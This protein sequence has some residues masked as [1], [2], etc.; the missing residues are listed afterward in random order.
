MYDFAV[1]QVAWYEK[2]NEYVEKFL[3]FCNREIIRSR[4][5][6]R[7]IAAYA[8]ETDGDDP[9]TRKIFGG[10]Y[11]SGDTRKLLRERAKY[12]RE[13]KH[14]NARIEHYRAEAAEYER[15]IG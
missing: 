5:E 10:K 4:A 13:R 1:G 12:Y 14:N 9:L 2:Q 6:D 15:F 11:V 3:G 8:L 7:R